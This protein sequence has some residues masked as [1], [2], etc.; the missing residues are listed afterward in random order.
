MRV[1]F[2]LILFAL[3][4]FCLSSAGVGQAPA[5][6]QQT[7]LPRV[8]PDDAKQHLLTFVQPD[9]PPLAKA[10]Q[11][12]GIVRVEVAIDDAGTV[13]V[14]KVISGHPL[15]VTTALEAIKRWKYKPFQVNGKPAAVRTDV[16]VSIP[17]N[18]SQTDIDSERKFQD[19]YW[20]NERAGRVA[21]EK[22]DLANAEAK[23]RIAY[24]AAKERGD[25]KWLEL[26]DVISMLGA[27]KE[28]QQA[29]PD[30]ETLL[31]E[32]LTIHE[33]HQHLDE[34][35]VASAKLSLGSL[36]VQ[37]NRLSEAEPLLL[38]AAK[39]WELHIDNAPM[40]EAKASYGR[41][42]ALSYFGA[43]QIAG[44]EGR[45]PDAQARCRKAV[46]YAEQWSSPSDK[47][48]IKS[49]CDALLSSN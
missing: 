26:A 8:T 20:E 3:Y 49:R 38:D 25:Q 36:Y 43:A 48:V 45:L 11:L 46:T 37:T 1:A 35:E 44:S 39:A 9:Y 13:K 6:P 29:Y 32:S 2:A 31:K 22:G 41:N 21:L 17:E 7:E 23:L 47:T 30:A 40:P 5:T 24:A 42:I 27:I 10:T 28:K 14:V 19:A 15:L 12:Q 4:I 34:A 16:E 33:K 18:I